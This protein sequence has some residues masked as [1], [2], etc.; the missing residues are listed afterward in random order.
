MIGKS[1]KNANAIRAYIRLALY[2]AEVQRIFILTYV[3]FMVEMKL[4]KLSARGDPEFA[5]GGAKTHACLDS[6]PTFEMVSKIRSERKKNMK[7]VT[8]DDSWIHK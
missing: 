5:H 2:S 7:V 3:L 6:A 4:K 1:V 8:G